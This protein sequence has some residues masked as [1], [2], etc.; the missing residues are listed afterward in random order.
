MMSSTMSDPVATVMA[1]RWV[2]PSHRIAAHSLAKS[3]GHVAADRR[4]ECPRNRIGALEGAWS[5]CAPR[6]TL[7]PDQASANLCDIA[8]ACA[9]ALPSEVRVNLITRV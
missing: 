7:D 9:R 2:Q 3:F 8:L 5:G 1:T 6:V 4:T